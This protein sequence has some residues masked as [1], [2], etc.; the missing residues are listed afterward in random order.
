MR[1]S[2]HPKRPSARTSCRRCVSKTCPIATEEH[3][4][5]VAV[6]VPLDGRQ[7]MDA[8][9]VSINGRFWVSTEASV[10][11]TSLASA[12]VKNASRRPP[13]LDRSSRPPVE[14]DSHTKF[15]GLYQSTGST[16]SP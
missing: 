1:R 12:S 5:L 4:L 14:S 9:E 8:F 13:N 3:E 15:N 16:N 2:D 11:M 10:S 7:E 6:N